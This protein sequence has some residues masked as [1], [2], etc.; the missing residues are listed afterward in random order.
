MSGS[1]FAGRFGF[2]RRGWRSLLQFF[3][4][5]SLCI[6][7]IVGCGGAPDTEQPASPAASEEA[8]SSRITMGTTQ[9]VE[10]LDP[11]DAYTIFT[12][13]LLY[14]MG[15][16]LY[17]YEPGTT[18]LVPQLATEMPTVS[19]DGLT[20]TIPLREGVTLHDGTAFN[21]EVMKFSIDRFIQNGGGPAFLLG[22]VVDSVEASGEYELTITLKAE[23][24][25][26]PALLSF[27]GVTPVPPD[28]YEIGEGSFKPDS[29][30]GSG[31]YKL[32][33]LNADSIKLDVNEDYWGEPPANQGIDIQIYASP[34]NLYNTFRTSGLDIAYQTLDPDQIASL[35]REED[36]G[37]WEVIEAG[38]NVINYMTLNQKIE[39]TSDLNVRKAI[40]AMIDRNLIN[41]RVF[42]GNAEP[43]YSMVPTSF[44]IYKPVFEQ[45]YGDGDFNKARA[46]LEE[47]GYSESNPLNFEIWYPS[48]ST[49]RSIIA[50]TLKESIE[51]GLPGLVTVAVNSAERATL[52]EGVDTGLY[53]T[54][55]LNWYPDFYDPDNFTQPFF[56]CDQGS[57]ETL[58][59]KGASQG[60]GSFYYSQKANDLITQERAEQDPA[61][62]DAVF[63]ELQDLSAEDVPYIPLWQNKD[64]VFVQDGIENVSIEPTQ[65]FLLWQISK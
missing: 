43:L 58:C 47:A 8:G 10:T 44:E 41:E 34:A 27:W 40:A 51:Q 49:E 4:L 63:T 48:A 42:Q 36:S 30:I 21:A 33:S 3:T 57:P 39:P 45:A 54:V 60:N 15:D 16:R 31:P 38:T 28:A 24:A 29:F 55:L 65:Q 62:R 19:D 37:G 64:Y 18:D 13:I 32:A 11:A 59:E 5:F 52:S 6:A 35:Q 25:G 53:E 26:F 12:G 61:A 50:N 17:T 46:F 20:Y 23:F 7:L 56:S 9:K 1:G 22:D 14:N 2:S